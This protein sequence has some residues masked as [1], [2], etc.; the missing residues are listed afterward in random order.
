M[1]SPKPSPWL[2]LITGNQRSWMAKTSS[3]RIAETNAG[4][5]SPSREARRVT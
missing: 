5:E 1:R 3:S 2:E 4:K